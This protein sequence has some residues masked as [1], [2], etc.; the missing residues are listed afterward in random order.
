MFFAEIAVDTYQDPRK[1]LFTYQIPVDLATRIAPG[2]QVTIPFGKRTAEGYVWKVGPKA[3][4]FPTKPIQSVKK[5][6]FSDKQVLLAHW[7]AGYYL[8]SPLE[9]LK[10]QLIGKGERAFGANP[11]K[12]TTLILVP[13]A[14]QVKIRALTSPTALVGSRSAV[15]S[16]LPHLKKIVIEEPENWNYKDERSPY[17]HAKDIAKKRAELEGLE[18][19]LRYQIPLVGDFKNDGAT[20]PEIKPVKVV[21]L[22]QEK[23]AG[24]FTFISQPLEKLI[25]ARRNTIVY[26]NSKEL[27]EGVDQEISKMGGDRNTVEIFGPELFSIVGKE[28]DYVV[29]ADTD[30]LLN[31]PDFRAHEKLVWTI[32]KLGQ[33][34]KK[35]LYLQTASPQHPLLIDLA[36]G[37][38]KNFYR[39]ELKNRQELSFPP[40]CTLVKLTYTSQSS[41]KTNLEAEKLSEVLSHLPPSLKVSPPYSPY[42]PTSATKWGARKIQLHLTIK[43]SQPGQLAKIIGEIDPEWKIEVDPESLL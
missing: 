21:D 2:V 14:S 17:Y 18:L 40:F 13:Y 5:R 33:I 6:V 26:T 4:S 37:T 27:R 10:C 25:S 7:M 35:T 23:S 39:R 1:K 12:T 24:N 3:P 31:L 15:F 11:E 42:S 22:G 32:A 38:L 8:A 30:T 29:W 9:C 19:E 34:A 43:A 28:T 16:Q 41:V 36:N 20:I